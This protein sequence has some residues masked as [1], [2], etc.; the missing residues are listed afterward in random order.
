LVGT[1][2]L[3]YAYVSSRL[4]LAWIVTKNNDCALS[5]SE[6]YVHTQR[7]DLLILQL[8][9]GIFKFFSIEILIVVSYEKE[10]QIFFAFSHY[11][12][13]PLNT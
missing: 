12:K 5:L 2:E 11:S 8:A 6:Y 7:S 3:F 10:E 4:L 13:L 1:T 9:T